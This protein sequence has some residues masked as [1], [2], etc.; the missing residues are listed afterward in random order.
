MG[1]WLVRQKASTAEHGLT[2]Q[3]DTWGEEPFVTGQVV[4]DTFVR[5]LS[6]AR[7]YGLRVNLDL[8]S[9]PGSQNGCV[10]G[11]R[12]AS[13]SLVCPSLTRAD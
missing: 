1:H 2:F 3:V 11:R 4:V 12:S 10:I 5:A 7:K 13:C 9:A 8:H 6:W